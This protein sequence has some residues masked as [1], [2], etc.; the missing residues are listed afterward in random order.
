MNLI[1]YNQLLDT[2]NDIFLKKGLC[3]GKIKNSYFLGPV[4]SR[5]LCLNCICLR[6]ISSVSYKTNKFVNL[7]KMEEDFL[8]QFSLKKKVMADIQR[9]GVI[10]IRNKKIYFTH[11]VMPV[12]GCDHESYEEK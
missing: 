12:P 1:K 3:L 4:L 5:N 8:I 6:T 9:G 10:E 2:K 7:S 11:Y